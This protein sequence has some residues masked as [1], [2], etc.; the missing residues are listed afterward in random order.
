MQKRCFVS[1][2]FKKYIY[3]YFLSLLS[4]GLIDMLCLERGAGRVDP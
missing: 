4:K 3:F 2:K 1:M